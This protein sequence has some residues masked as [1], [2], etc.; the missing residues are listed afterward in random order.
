M[1]LVLNHLLLLLLLLTLAHLRLLL[2]LL[3]LIVIL[4]ILLILFDDMLGGRVIDLEH[5][6]RLLDRLAAI[7]KGYQSLTLL[8]F[9][10]VVAAF[11]PSLILIHG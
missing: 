1:L 2:L 4:W 9:H 8:L 5:F 6:G 10:L 7:K 3:F 11:L